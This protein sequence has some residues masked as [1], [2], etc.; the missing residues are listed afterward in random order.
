MLDPPSRCH[1]LNAHWQD[2]SFSAHRLHHIFSKLYMERLWD[3]GASRPHNKQCQHQSALLAINARAVGVF[4]PHALSL[5]PYSLSSN[6]P[7]HNNL[8]TS[9]TMSISMQDI[10]PEMLCNCQTGAPN[11]S[12][13]DIRP[14]PL[15]D[16]PQNLVTVVDGESHGTNPSGNALFHSRAT[17]RIS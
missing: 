8:Y 11:D 5:N 12:P 15:N 14:N 6:S 4:I 17:T 1:G 10:S 2:P 16:I 13:Q 7:N 3:C 9:R